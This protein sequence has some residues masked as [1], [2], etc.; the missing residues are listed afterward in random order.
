M[1]TT[2]RRSSFAGRCLTRRSRGPPDSDVSR[3]AQE[4]IDVIAHELFAVCNHR[5]AGID[6]VELP[7]RRERAHENHAEHVRVTGS[8]TSLRDPLLN[9]TLERRFATCHPADEVDLSLLG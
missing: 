8:Q 7:P 2:R 9:Q 5:A 4:V 3:A 6:S 1:W